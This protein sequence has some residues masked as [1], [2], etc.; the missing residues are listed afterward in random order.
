M[1]PQC[2]HL[3][4]HISEK[5]SWSDNEW[6]SYF[7]DFKNVLF[8]LND[9]WNICLSDPNPSWVEVGWIDLKTKYQ[10]NHSLHALFKSFK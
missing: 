4:R 7:K 2:L 9:M 3:V 5:R 8:R 10:F 1:I 6:T